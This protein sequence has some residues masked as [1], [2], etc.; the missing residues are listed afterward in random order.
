MTSGSSSPVVSTSARMA[1]PSGMS[2]TPLSFQR[3]GCYTL[4]RTVTMNGHDRADLRN[5]L[6][7]RA[8]GAAAVSRD[9]GCDPAPDAG[10]R[11]SEAKAHRL[12]RRYSR[13]AD[14]A[15]LQLAYCVGF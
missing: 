12:L 9:P 2:E 5:P 1:R 7:L 8:V 4:F 14:A 3:C 11:A 15:G 13:G 10:R 6:H